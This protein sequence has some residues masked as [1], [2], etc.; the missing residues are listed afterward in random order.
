MSVP[1][2]RLS[3]VSIIP[4]LNHDHLYVHAAPGNIQKAVPFRKLGTVGQKRTFTFN[5]FNRLKWL[6]NI[7]KAVKM[8]GAIIV[9]LPQIP[10]HL[11]FPEACRKTLSTKEDGP[12]EIDTSHAKPRLHSYPGDGLQRSPLCLNVIWAEQMALRRNQYFR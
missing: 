10:F 2:I 12:E 9:F 3:P 1:V 6:P 4:L 11:F 5:L 8:R 7:R